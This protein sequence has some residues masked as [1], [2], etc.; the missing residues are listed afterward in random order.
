VHLE[1]PGSRRASLVRE[2]LRVGRQLHV[3]EVRVARA[4]RVRVEHQRGLVVPRVL[5]AVTN[6]VGGLRTE[7]RIRFAA[8]ERRRKRCRARRRARRAG[9]EADQQQRPNHH[10]RPSEKT[11][12]RNLP[13]PRLGLSPV[14]IRVYAVVRG[15]SS[16]A[17][18][19]HHRWNLR[20]ARCCGVRVDHAAAFLGLRPLTPGHQGPLPPAGA[21]KNGDCHKHRP[22]RAPVNLVPPGTT[23]VSQRPEATATGA[24]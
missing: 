3:V 16:E 9:E 19:R 20:G 15:L 21:A 1:V 6:R 13:D 2:H 12:H 8:L 7:R 18:T 22:K 23:A 5:V 17:W 14:R 11:L 10:Q 4:R 24:P